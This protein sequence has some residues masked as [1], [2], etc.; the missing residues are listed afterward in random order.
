MSMLLLATPAQAQAQAQTTTPQAADE[1]VEEIV[2][3]GSILRRTNT[4]TASPV[5]TLTSESLENRGVNTIGEALQRLAAN[6]S[7]AINEGWNNGSNFAAGANAASLRGLTVQATLTVFDGLRMAPYPVADDGHRNFVDLS[8][9]PDAIIERLEVLKDGASAT[10]G[11]DAVAG[12]INVITKKQVQGVHLNVSGGISSRGDGGEQRYDLTAG[13][14]DLEE[15]GFNI[16]VNG[17]YRK[18]DRIQVS[19]RD[20]PFNT[21]DLSRICA[22]GSTTNCLNNG[23]NFG[24]N[25]NGTLS[26]ATTT[27]ALL[28]APSSATGARLGVY[29]LI[30][31]AACQQYGLNPVTLTAAQQ[32]TTWGANQC[33]QDNYAKYSSIRP[34]T[35]RYGFSVRATAKLGDSAEIYATGNYYHTHT[36]AEIS[37]L[38]YAN[39]TA[40]PNGVTFNPVVLPVYVCAQGIGTFAAARGAFY[41][42]STGCSA[43]NGTL[44]PNNPLAASGSLAI[45][46]GRYDRPRT[47]ETDGRAIRGAM[48]IE[49]DFGSNDDWHYQVDFTAS[50]VKLTRTS[51]NYLVPQG[52]ADVIA[53]G[54]FNFAEPWKNSEAVRQIVA[55]TSVKDSVSKLWQ[56]QA[57]V[58]HKFAELAGGPLQAAVGLAYRKE[59]INDQ[60]ANPDDP[61]R[62]F[63]R[64]YSVNAVGAVG[65]R[66]VKS[67]FFEISA[68]LI[69]KLELNGSGRYD[70]YS[71]GQTNF[72]PKVTIKYKPAEWLALRG[73]WS[74][75]FRIPSFNE[76][77]GLPTTGFTTLQVNC[78]TYATFCAAHGNN[79]YAI[80]QYSLGRTSVGNPALKP[81]KSQ[82]WTVGAVVEPNRHINFTV[83]YFNIK[84]K[85]LIGN[86][87]ASTQTAALD[88]YFRNNGVVNIPG[89]VVKPQVSDAAFPNALPLPGSI[90]FSFSN[91]DQ[92]TVSGIDFSLNTNY[93]LGPVNWKSTVDASYVLRYEIRRDDGSIE[94]YDGS[95]SPCDYTSCSGTPK[96][97]GSWDNTF[98]IDKWSLNMTAYYTGGYDLASVDYGGIPGDCEGSI[99]ASVVTYNDGVTPVRCKTGP[100]WNVD[101]GIRYKMNDHVTL[102]GNVLNVFDIKP[103]FDPSATYSFTQ[104]NV[105]WA[106]ANAVGRYFRVG[107]KID[108]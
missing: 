28:Y 50:E 47:V 91:S 88:Q 106:Q 21:A 83:D 98:S 55:P 72:S 59:S 97:R 24:I 43:A 87:A 40:A 31:P 63:S 56:V 6:G 73:T 3:T 107:A 86:I 58:Q 78:T 18:N 68:P 103:P 75:G 57:I 95:L 9:I 4:E 99:G 65:S 69:D 2:V 85:D 22:P 11:A 49:G 33:Q 52:I 41:N 60:S 13:Y 20:Y 53:K 74:K 67:A 46:R 8:T 90:E 44:N 102:Y 25:A 76:A 37:P 14:G 64:Y 36:F 19:D 79:N 77:F 32:G 26:A 10:Y 34:D 35:E 51:D 84:V 27:A 81:E 45:L 82:S 101:M 105:T 70:D 16:Y 80:G 66:N 93:D 62:P 71:S 12:V 29:N 42:V 15:Q 61:V 94:R 7:G 23:V 89:I 48:G 54:T 30:N 5:V 108:F 92:E 1:K 39:A 96:W 17:T 38:G 100:T 104:Y